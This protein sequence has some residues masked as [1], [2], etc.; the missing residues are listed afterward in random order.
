MAGTDGAALSRWNVL[1]ELTDEAEIAGFIQA[2]IDEGASP[3]SIAR[4]VAKGAQ[5]RAVNQMARGTGI[6][7]KLLCDMFLDD[8]DGGAEAINANAEAIVRAARAFAMP[9]EAAPAHA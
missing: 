7:R 4:A 3:Y 6:D 1:E 9:L 2:V 5:A 8:V